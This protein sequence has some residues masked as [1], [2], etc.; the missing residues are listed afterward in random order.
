MRNPAFLLRGKQ[1]HVSA[2]LLHGCTES[3]FFTVYKV[4]YLLYQNHKF[5]ISI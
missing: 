3:L 4:K 2:V 5:H 1:R